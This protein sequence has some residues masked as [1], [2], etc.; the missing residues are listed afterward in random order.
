MSKPAWGN[1]PPCIIKTSKIMK[2]I[3]SLAVALMLCT[4]TFVLSSCSNNDDPL[5]TAPVVT[6]AEVGE[7][8][9][10]EAIAGHD[11]HLEGELLAEALI[12]RID[13]TIASADGQRVVV[14]KSWTESK[15]I[16][17]KNCTFH[18]HIDIP[19]ATIAGSY[20]LTFVVT[21]KL[22]QSTTFTSDLN[23]SKAIEGIPVI[24]FKEVG[25][26]NSKKVV[27]G[28][29]MHLEAQIEATHKIA[30]IEVEFHNVAAN[31]E[32]VFTYT[33]EKYVGETSVLFHEHPQIPSDAPVG[34]YHLHFTVTD[35]NGNVT[36]EE[37]EG[38]QVI[39]E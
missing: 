14:N 3:L 10:K 22:G 8:N 29:K 26:D 18:E 34:E 21:D 36:T 15:Y 7:E 17:V 20:R 1:S 33:D 35:C 39:A 13:V 24:T 9:S 16:G 12:A 2:K 30:K 27:V 19:E 5:V 11:L 31:Y 25:E 38:I 23:I 37:A 28:Q 6:L 4:F 32:K